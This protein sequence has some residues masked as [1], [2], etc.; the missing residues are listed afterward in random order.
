MHRGAFHCHSTYSDGECTLA[1]LRD[2]FV[3]AGLDFVCMTD[4]AEFFDDAKLR[5]Y[6]AECES[7]SDERFRFVAG[8]EYECERR[9]H[10]LGYG[11]TTL[12]GTTDPQ[13]VI[14]HVE[15]EGGV[16]VIAHPMD[17]M[18]DWIETFDTLPSGVEA[19]NTKYDGR[20]APRRGTFKL[21]RRL[22]ERKPELRAFYGTD[23]H[24]RHQYRALSNVLT[25]EG[26]PTRDAVLAAL[27]RGDFA[28][29][30]GELE[31][32]SSGELSEDL[33]AR[34]DS[35]NSRYHLWRSFLKKAKKMSGRI[36]KR[37]PAPV[38]AQLRRIF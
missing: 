5:A 23:F 29:V 25:L 17:S 8:L 34:F 38:K 37:L 3:A 22:Q 4:H 20:Y 19:W 21:I 10:V 32:P 24:W 28:G 31:L 36:G 30:K 16:S 11:V 1:E 26:T 13:G 33:L 2:M 9:M 35:V 6:V 18:F 15:R 12:A 7:L 27:R 14:R